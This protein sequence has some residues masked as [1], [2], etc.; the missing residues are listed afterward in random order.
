MIR[1]LEIQSYSWTF[2]IKIIKLKEQQNVYKNLYVV[3]AV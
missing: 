2:F 1:Y 3:A